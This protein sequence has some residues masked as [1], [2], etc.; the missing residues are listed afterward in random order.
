MDTDRITRSRT[1]RTATKGAK[2]GRRRPPKSEL[3]RR[4]I[5]DAAA[6]LFSRKGYSSTSLRDIGGRADILSGSIY[7]YFDTKDD[8]LDAVLQEGLRALQSSVREA[9]E[10][11]PKDAQLRQRLSAAIHAHL[12]AVLSKSDY[13]RANISEYQRAS[14]EVRARNLQL[15]HDYADY[16]RSLLATAQESNDI[17]A[18]VDLTLL[19]L[20]ILG[21]LNWAADWFDPR[22][23]AVEEISEKFTDYVCNGVAPQATNKKSAARLSAT[24]R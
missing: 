15:R 5:L 13:V 7:Y 23:D 20:F 19:R 2:K 14:A 24:R 11:L 18:N 4:K 12:A 1:P 8:I 6:W 17:H 3:T 21:A 10:S 16:W 22:K 9:V